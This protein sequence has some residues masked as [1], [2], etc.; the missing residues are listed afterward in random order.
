MLSG[1]CLSDDAFIAFSQKGN[2]NLEREPRKRSKRVFI[3]KKPKISDT[4]ISFITFETESLFK[5]YYV[6]K[7]Q[8][9][10]ITFAV[11]NLEK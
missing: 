2:K 7:K 4:K 8:T 1:I 3:K 5:K 9:L 6:A 10:F 11:R